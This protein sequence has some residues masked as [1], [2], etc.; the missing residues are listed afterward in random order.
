MKSIFT[1]SSIAGIITLVILALT[2]VAQVK[3]ANS[4][5]ELESQQTNTELAKSFLQPD[6]SPD[7]QMNE[8]SDATKVSLDPNSAFCR[9]NWFLS[10]CN[11]RYGSES[12]VDFAN[13]YARVVGPRRSPRADADD[14][15]MLA[16]IPPLP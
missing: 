9:K 14:S 8:D 10:A 16:K 12:G 6:I 11:A 5:N 1:K 15:V 3:A 7:W 13:Q 2:P 4:L